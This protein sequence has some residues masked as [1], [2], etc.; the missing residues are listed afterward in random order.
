MSLHVIAMDHKKWELRIRAT[1]LLELPIRNNI[2]WVLLEIWRVDF[3]AFAIWIWQM[4]MSPVSRDVEQQRSSLTTPDYDP[5]RAPDPQD[6]IV[7]GKCLVLPGRVPQVPQKSVWNF[8]NHGAS[9]GN[10]G[11]S[12]YL[13]VFQVGLNIWAARHHFVGIL[14]LLSEGYEIGTHAV[15]QT[16]RLGA[17]WRLLWSIGKSWQFMAIHGNSWQIMAI[18]GNCQLLYNSTKL[19]D[20]NS[21]VEVWTKLC[22]R[23]Y[24][25]SSSLVRTPNCGHCCS[26]SLMVNIWL[27][28]GWYFL[29]VP[30]WL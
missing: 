11:I 21:A 4:K 10:G 27:I 8:E 1:V 20:Q 29:Q 7:L 18:H 26:I 5:P 6:G 30:L 25:L 28:Y 12:R 13:D 9:W 14:D 22:L 24:H 15:T 2:S 19:D 17:H 3:I 23:S 16:K